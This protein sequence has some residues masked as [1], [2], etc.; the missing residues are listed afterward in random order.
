M[1]EA[2]WRASATGAFRVNINIVIRDNSGVTNSVTEV[3]SRELKLNMRGVSILSR[4]D[5]TAAG[6][7]S[8]EVPNTQTVDIMIHALQRLRDVIRVSRSKS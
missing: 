4:P 7:I 6:T 3:I 5:G 2:A 8:V 1:M